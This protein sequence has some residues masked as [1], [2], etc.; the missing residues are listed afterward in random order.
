MKRVLIGVLVLAAALAPLTGFATTATTTQNND[1]EPDAM[2]ALMRMAT[3]LADA[4]RFSVTADISYDVVQRWGQKIE[5]GS[6]RRVTVRRPDRLRADVVDRDG[7]RT[8][9][10]FDGRAISVFLPDRR[11]YAVAP[12]AGSLDDA[13]TYFVEQLDMR[14][15][16][17]ELFSSDLPQRLQAR[18]E[19]A[20]V[21]GMETVRHV[22]CV[23]LALRADDVDIQVWTQAEGTPLLR[24]LVITYRQVVGQPEFRADLTDWNLSPEVPDALF[25]FTPPAGAERIPFVARKPGPGAVRSEGAT[26]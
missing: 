23:H 4:E 1:V 8:G 6:V 12:R 20:R 9:I 24:R 15:P 11:V 10:T 16:G 25:D 2:A 17:R 18:V 14:L 26:R 3:A 7:T 19:S 5:F 13:L 22:R 21:V